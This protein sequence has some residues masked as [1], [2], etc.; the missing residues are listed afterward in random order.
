MP[1]QRNEIDDR[2]KAYNKDAG[3]FWL[4]ELIKYLPEGSLK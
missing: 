1:I 3:E 2:V 4:R